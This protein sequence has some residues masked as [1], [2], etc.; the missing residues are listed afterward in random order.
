MTGKAKFRKLT[1]VP[2]PQVCI[3][4]GFWTSRLRINREVSIPRQLQMCE[5][6]GRI[7][8]FKRAARRER[9]TFQGKRF[10]DSDV[11]KWLEAACYAIA[12]S[13]DAGLEKK[14]DEVIQIIGKA[15]EKDGYLNA[16]FTLM[17]PD[18]KWKNLGMMHE[19]YCAGHLFQAAVAHARTTGKKTLLQ[20]AC[21]LAD[22]IDSTFGPG[23]RRGY[24]GHEEIEMALLELSSVTGEGRYFNLAKYFL[25]QRGQK[26]SVFER[27]LEQA[28]LP[29]GLDEYRLYFTKGGSYDGAYAQDHLPIRE[30]V[31]VAGHAVRAMYLY[32]AMTE[33]AAETGEG[34]LL[35]VLESLW[36]NLTQKHLYITGSIGPRSSNE[37]FAGEYDLPNDSAYAETC[38][39]VGLVMWS[40][41]MAML[42]GEGRFADVMEQALYNG[43][44]S[45]VSLDGKMYF[46][47]N[48]LQSRG[49]HHRQDWY[50]CACCPSNLSRLLASLGGYIYAQSPES[51]WVNLY[52]GST[53]KTELEKAGKIEL[54]QVTSYPLSGSV[55]FKVLPERPADFAIHLRIPGW[56]E[57][58]EVRLNGK[59]LS[60]PPPHKGYLVVRKNWK[61]GDVFEF[62]LPMDVQAMEAHPR[63]KYN[64]GRVAL[65][66]GPLVYCFEAADNP[67]PLHTLA[68]PDRSD[69]QPC[70]EPN[71]LRGITVLRGQGMADDL[72]GWENR[73]YRKDRR[74]F[75]QVEIAAIPYYAW[76]NREGGEMAVWMRR[77]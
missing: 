11:Y 47:E 63:L 13:P 17:D 16:Y 15:Q 37:G 3:E 67:W 14:I 2:F 39:A 52:V 62:T 29:G 5:E 1:S 53:M 33:L 56:C 22:H 43:V 44:L 32:C 4:E 58:W 6:T 31:E 69:F 70:F 72:S 34:A 51:L 8:N 65:Q 68:I 45:G 41:R 35:E 59:P 46:Y 23:K 40:H 75:Q 77:G 25:D 27:E 50:D 49:N 26:P 60:C 36:Q 30:Q 9:G 18:R 24:P 76:D 64:A 21:R 7:D 12:A 73:L 28:D 48:P 42:H 10:N 55:A 20:V 74:A 19:L 61:G 71:L 57:R 38:A 54:Q 66:R